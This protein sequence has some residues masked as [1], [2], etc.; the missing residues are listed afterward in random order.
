MRIVKRIGM[1]VFIV[2]CGL[3]Y[4]AG[5]GM[6]GYVLMNQQEV[7]ID[8][9]VSQQTQASAIVEGDPDSEK[10]SEKSEK[11]R[12]GNPYRRWLDG[13]EITKNKDGS[14]SFS[15]VYLGDVREKVPR[16]AGL[17]DRELSALLSNIGNILATRCYESAQIFVE[18]EQEFFYPR[19]TLFL[20]GD[21]SQNED[22]SYSF[23]ERYLENAKQI[24]GM[25]QY[26]DEQ[27]YEILNEMGDKLRRYT[28]ENAK[29]LI[30]EQIRNR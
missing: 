15:E 13:E 30:E 27:V 18:N 21:I 8:T 9:T 11:T 20:Q 1:V 3:I 25:E 19:G 5:I 7:I 16:L 23:T 17:D 14:Y 12:Y 29:F 6:G 26:S 4:I 22:G 24:E 28:G 2:I 10:E